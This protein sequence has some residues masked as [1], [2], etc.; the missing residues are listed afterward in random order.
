[1][2]QSS[3]SRKRRPPRSSWSESEAKQKLHQ[4]EPSP[5]SMSIS[6][7]TEISQ[8]ART[9]LGLLKDLLRTARTHM[10]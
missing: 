10:G 4:E 9:R 2:C 1:M 7:V 8:E 5:F 3:P 6:E